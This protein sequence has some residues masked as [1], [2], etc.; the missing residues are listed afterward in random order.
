LQFDAS[1]AQLMNAI[2]RLPG[3]HAADSSA[4]ERTWLNQR[5]RPVRRSTTK[6]IILG[7]ASTSTVTARSS[8][9][10]ATGPYPSAWTRIVNRLIGLPLNELTPTIPAVPVSPVEASHRPLGERT[11]P[12]SGPRLPLPSAFIIHSS[13]SLAGCGSRLFTPPNA[14]SRP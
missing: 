5:S 4:R 13:A 7:A 9:A 2:C 12:R 10:H 11:S 6:I 3:D 14:I 1:I 8:G